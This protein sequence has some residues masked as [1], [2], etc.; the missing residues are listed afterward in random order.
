VSGPSVA[1]LLDAALG[2]DVATSKWYL[3]ANSRLPGPRA[4]LELL[5]AYDVAFE[6][7]DP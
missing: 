1:E 2:G 6:R 5:V 7:I 4:N 3:L